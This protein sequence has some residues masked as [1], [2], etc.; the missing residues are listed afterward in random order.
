M[1]QPSSLTPE[2][3][4]QVLVWL[5]ASRPPGETHLACDYQ[6]LMEIYCV[7]KT[8]GVQ[9][10][11]QAS[12]AF[13]QREQTRLQGELAQA[14][15]AATTAALRQEIVDLQNSTRWRLAFLEGIS[16][17]EEAAVAAVLPLLEA[18]HQ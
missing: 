18:Q 16:P 9:V 17:P 14:Q 5:E 11:R 10:Q 13:Q 2:R 4:H 12:L 8:G 6:R 15:D 1:S 3:I 7:V